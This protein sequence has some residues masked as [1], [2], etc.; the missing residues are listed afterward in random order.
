M[1][2]RSGAYAGA[3][4]VKPFCSKVRSTGHIQKRT[5]RKHIRLATLSER[6]IRAIFGNLSIGAPL[7]WYKT[8]RLAAVPVGER[9]VNG[10]IKRA[11]RAGYTFNG[12]GDFE[13]VLVDGLNAVGHG[14]IEFSLGEETIMVIEFGPVV[15]DSF[16]HSTHLS[17]DHSV[18]SLQHSHAI[19]QRIW[20]AE[21]TA[22][23]L[24]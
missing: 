20:F 10:A 15:G 21:Q 16:V 14:H 2:M 23:I 4:H 5:T 7:R 3:P 8:R 12:Y 11:I 9:S 6:A 22:P 19:R 18:L 13:V 1:Q 17:S 24:G